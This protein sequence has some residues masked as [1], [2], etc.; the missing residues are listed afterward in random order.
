MWRSLRAAVED[1]VKEFSREAFTDAT[2]TLQDV[3]GFW[4][5]LHEMLCMCELYTCNAE[6]LLLVLRLCM[7]P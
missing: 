4:A 7:L 3:S 6:A 2:T 5:Q 1:G